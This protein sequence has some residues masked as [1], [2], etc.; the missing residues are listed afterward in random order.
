MQRALAT[1][2]RHRISDGGGRWGQNRGVGQ[3]TVA[4]RAGGYDRIRAAAG[5]MHA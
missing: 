5:G 4:A 2:S 3:D 1:C